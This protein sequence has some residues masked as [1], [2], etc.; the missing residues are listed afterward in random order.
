MSALGLWLCF[1]GLPT[2]R[3]F[4]TLSTKGSQIFQHLLLDLS[5]CSLLCWVL[6]CL[7][8]EAVNFSSEWIIH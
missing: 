7:S 5:H 2:F 8:A 3:E 4:M 6:L 1:L